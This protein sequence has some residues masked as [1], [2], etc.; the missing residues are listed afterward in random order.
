MDNSQNPYGEVPAGALGGQ[1]IETLN[2]SF[3]AM[4]TPETTVSFLSKTQG[5]FAKYFEEALSTC[6]A[7]FH[8]FDKSLGEKGERVAVRKF[9]LVLLEV[10]CKI[11]G[12]AKN[13][14]GSYLNY[15]S[16]YIKDSRTEPFYVRCGGINNVQFSGLY[17]DIKNQKLMPKGVGFHIHF[18]CYCPQLDRVVDVML[19]SALSRAFQKSVGESTGKKWD[20][21]FLF[22][23]CEDDL[24][25]GFRLNGYKNVT[26]EGF[27]YQSGDLFIE[28]KFVCGIV[29]PASPKEEMKLWHAKAVEL[30]TQIRDDYRAKNERRDKNK[31]ASEQGQQQNTNTPPANNQ[32][33]PF[34]TP[35]APPQK[36]H[37]AFLPGPDDD[38]P[39]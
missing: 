3:S 1:G 14:D 20:K 11:S 2:L 4:K 7:G 39:F 31:P 25:W 12:A 10:Y 13:D 23:L 21:V 28:P 35:T 5:D 18:F 36:D 33:A 6:K 27:D 22:N 38:L 32:Q 17:A 24:I 8:Y 15:Y 9:D 37:S 34:E 30:Q 16:N 19:T 26:L 29:S